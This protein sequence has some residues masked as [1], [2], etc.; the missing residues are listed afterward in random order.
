MGMLARNFNPM[1][2]LNFKTY[3]INEKCRLFVNLNILEYLDDD[4]Q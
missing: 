2:N 1:H 4:L 3:G